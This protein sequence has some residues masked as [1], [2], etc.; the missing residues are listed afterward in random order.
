MRWLPKLRILV[1]LSVGR[2]SHAASFPR[3]S[4]WRPKYSTSVTAT[5]KSTWLVKAPT[6]TRLGSSCGSWRPAR[7]RSG[8]FEKTRAFSSRPS[9]AAPCT[10]RWQSSARCATRA[11]VPRCPTST[12]RSPASSR[13]AGAPAPSTAPAPPPSY[14]TWRH[15]PDS[16]SPHSPC[17][18]R[19][20]WKSVMRE[21]HASE[22]SR[23]PRRASLGTASA[24]PQPWQ[25]GR[26]CACLPTTMRC[27]AAAW[28]AAF[29]FSTPTHTK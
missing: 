5:K 19:L 22:S 16:A 4:G 25:R 23:W 11:S 15:S 12:T 13:R 28:M 2:A 8:S 20:S 9:K 14:S 26:R 21:S 27:G 18:L 29:V 10:G 7:S 3:G 17:R 24:P 6:F 1:S